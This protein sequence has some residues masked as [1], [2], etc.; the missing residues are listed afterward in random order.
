MA[1]VHDSFPLEGS[2]RIERIATVGLFG[3]YD[4]DL[5]LVDDT[6]GE[7]RLNILYGDNGSGKTT[8]LTLIFHLLSSAGNRGHRGSL[9]SVPFKSFAVGLA[10][11][12]WL[13]IGREQA[14][15]G[16]YTITITKPNGEVVSGDFGVE[17]R[18]LKSELSTDTLQALDFIESLSVPIFFL[19]DDRRLQSDAFP[20]DEEQLGRRT[21]REITPDPRDYYVSL[22][23]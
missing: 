2:S 12:V 9:V 10:S 1:Y 16:Q 22:A 20:D 13:E 17:G 6:L 21:I 18:V 23:I 4:Y 7:S 11:G 3:R 15:D 19:G 5:E 14:T 8:I